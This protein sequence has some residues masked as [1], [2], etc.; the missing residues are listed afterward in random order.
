MR[1]PFD[2][3]DEEV[4]EEEEDDEQAMLEHDAIMEFNQA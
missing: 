3:V 1:F 4:G 2:D